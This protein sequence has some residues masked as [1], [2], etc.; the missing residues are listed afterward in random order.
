MSRSR[1][2]SSLQDNSGAAAIEFALG[3]MPLITLLLG[4]I[5]Y[6]G[7]FASVIALEHAASEG[8]RAGIAGISVCERKARAESVAQNALHFAP[9]SDTAVIVATVTEEQIRVDIGVNYAANPI[10]PAIFPVPTQLNTSV[11]VLTDGTE[12]SA[13]PC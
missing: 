4:G 9:L 10:T 11:V 12:L 5:T 7:V 1:Y 8:A 6:G 13:Q 2:L 3:I